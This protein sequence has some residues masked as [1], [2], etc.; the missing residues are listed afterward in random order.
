MFRRNKKPQGRLGL[1]YGDCIGYGKLAGT[2]F[3]VQISVEEVGR[4]GEYSQIKVRNIRGLPSDRL[5]KQAAGMVEEF[6]PTSEI[7]WLTEG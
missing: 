3:E 2:T 1:I 7:E 6:I 4:S 5:Y